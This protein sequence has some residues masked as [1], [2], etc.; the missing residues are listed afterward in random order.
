MRIKIPI[1]LFL[2]S[3]FYIGNQAQATHMMG[4]DMSYQCLGNG[5]YKITAK[6]YRDCRGIGLSNPAFGAFAGSNGSNQCGSV[7]LSG[8]KLKVFAT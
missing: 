6:V 2:L 3:F 1:L 8:L 4:A 5:K 7:N